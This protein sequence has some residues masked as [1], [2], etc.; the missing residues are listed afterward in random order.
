MLLKYKRPVIIL[1]K[2]KR[3]I[4][5]LIPTYKCLIR[6][7]FLL[8]DIFMS[9]NFCY[10]SLNFLNIMYMLGAH[11]IYVTL[12]SSN[13]YTLLI[14]S[15]RLHKKHIYII[16]V[17]AIC[18][19]K[20]PSTCTCFFLSSVRLDPYQHPTGCPLSRCHNEIIQCMVGYYD[21]V[22]TTSSQRDC[23]SHTTLSHDNLANLCGRQSSSHRSPLSETRH[24]SGNSLLTNI[25][26]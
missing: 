3:H 8:N 14:C 4:I 11:L 26:S 23:V 5:F 9:M 25:P 1:K 20:N 16:A 13:L 2:L 21:H 6:H 17:P 10:V 19:S 24:V 22:S 15:F 7:L 12:F 18:C